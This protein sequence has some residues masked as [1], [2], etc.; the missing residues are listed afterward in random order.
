MSITAEMPVTIKDTSASITQA[1][2]DLSRKRVLVGIPSSNN[3]RSDGSS[4]SNAARAYVFEFGAP[5]IGMPARPS[6][7]PG[8]AEAL[9][10]V[11]IA[12]G[13]AAKAALA[14]DED[15]VDANLTIA[16]TKA[17]NSVIARIQSNIP[18]PLR[19]A[20]IARRRIR[21]KGSSYRRKATTAADVVALI[22]T[23]EW[24]RAHTFVVE[25]R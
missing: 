21:S 13:A 2:R 4:F 8:V 1:L 12:L 22:D 5:E 16:G 15:K 14:G 10:E 3:D 11:K 25:K 9:P 18:P 7:I 6:L 20:T 23:G 17:N 19:P 24:L